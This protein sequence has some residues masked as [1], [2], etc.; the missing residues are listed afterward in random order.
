M[1]LRRGFF[2]AWMVLSICWMGAIAY[3]EFFLLCA[4]Y[5]PAAVKERQDKERAEYLECIK[6]KSDKECSKVIFHFPA[7]GPQRD[8]WVVLWEKFF[9]PSGCFPRG[10]YRADWSARW[11]ALSQMLSVPASTL[12]VGLVLIWIGSGFRSKP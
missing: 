7:P 8:E 12:I 1:N 6:T 4:S 3:Q 9:G 10:E 2:R 5:S 11:V